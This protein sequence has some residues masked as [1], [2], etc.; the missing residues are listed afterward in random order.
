M[1]IY[2]WSGHAVAYVVEENLYGWNGQHTGWFVNGVLYN[3]RGQRAGSIGG[4]CPCALYAT[5]VSSDQR[6]QTQGFRRY[7]Q[8]RHYL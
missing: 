6:G 4:K 7:S 1:S 8:G 3:R 5:P 2:L